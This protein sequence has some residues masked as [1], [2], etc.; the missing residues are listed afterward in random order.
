MG[1]Q[2]VF[3]PIEKPAQLVL[4]TANFGNK[5]GIVNA[6]RVEPLV[7]FK[8]AKELGMRADSL[9]IH[10][11]DT[12][13]TYGETEKWLGEVS[14]ELDIE[15][16]TKILI[17]T[18][19]TL[20]RD[21]IGFLLKKS[22]D[23]FREDKLTC[24]QIHNWSPNQVYGYESSVLIDMIRTFWTG[25]IGASTYGTTSALAALDL[26]DMVHFEFN[27]LNQETYRNLFAKVQTETDYLGVLTARSIFL[28]GLLFRDPQT[29][30]LNLKSLSDSIIEIRKVADDFK[31][32][33]QEL[34]IRGTLSMPGLN[35]IVIG[36][37]SISQLEE[38][39]HYFNLGVLAEEIV[40]RMYKLDNSSNPMVD[41]RNWNKS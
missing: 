16:W 38:T 21:E 4:G 15:I 19:T 5:Y 31:M 27:L 40:D 14:E 11:F 13:S 26:F 6:T 36:V 37:D 1:M 7:D 29:I 3:K 17:P 22:I 20:Q 8:N 24:I 30:P 32:S 33:L 18:Q 12:A 39:V 23:N 2:N 10:I 34:V 35:F 41:P 25:K 28:Q 9:G